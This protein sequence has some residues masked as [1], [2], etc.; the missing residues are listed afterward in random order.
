M[1]F[2]REKSWWFTLHLPEFW[3][4]GNGMGI[5]GEW[6]LRNDSLSIR[7]ELF[8]NGK[9]NVQRCSGLRN[10]QIGT[11]LCNLGYVQNME[12]TVYQKSNRMGKG[13]DWWS[14]PRGVKWGRILMD[15]QHAVS[16]GCLGYPL[17]I[18]TLV[19]NRVWNRF[20]GN[21]R[22]QDWNVILMRNRRAAGGSRHGLFFFRHGSD[23]VTARRRR[24]LRIFLAFFHK[25]LDPQ[26]WVFIWRMSNV[27]YTS[28][29]VRGCVL[30]Y[31]HTFRHIQEKLFLIKRH[32]QFCILHFVTYLSLP[33]KKR[34][35]C[36][37]MCEKETTQKKEKTESKG[38]SV[39]NRAR[40]RS[41]DSER[42]R[43]RQ[44]V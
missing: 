11:K 44:C 16:P 17:S 24:R 12:R 28:D 33:K 34:V 5:H 32:Q 23:N 21:G 14:W 19:S 2:S 31:I 41:S 27:G 35:V 26:N 37:C 6:Q 10:G 38:K 39:R 20:W 43:A 15:F 30:P 29:P 18:K 36:M 42:E 1:S 13:G 9:G 8:P 22:E 25:I 4:N 40:G 3:G 7:E